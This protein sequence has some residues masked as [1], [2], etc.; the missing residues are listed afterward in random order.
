MKNAENAENLEVLSIPNPGVDRVSYQ[1]RYAVICSV[2]KAPFGGKID[3]SFEPGELLLEFESFDRWLASLVM[4]EMTIEGLCR[5]VF[6]RLTAVLGDIP[7]R[8]RVHAETTVHAPA[9]A[10]ISRS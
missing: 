6:D 10:S 9:R 2:G 8:V 3:I 4:K 5:L 1:P 7:L